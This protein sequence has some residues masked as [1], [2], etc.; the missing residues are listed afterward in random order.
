MDDLHAFA[1]FADEDG[2]EESSKLKKTVVTIELNS[3]K[4]NSK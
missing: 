3:G 2:V 4:R 1:C